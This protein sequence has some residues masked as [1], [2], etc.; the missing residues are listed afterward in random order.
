ME[1]AAK[2]LSHQPEITAV[3]TKDGS[4]VCVPQQWMQG[5]HS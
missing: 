4:R 5:K 1:E 3:K 2:R